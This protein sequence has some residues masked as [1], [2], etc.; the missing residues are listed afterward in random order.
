ML[1]LYFVAA[2]CTTPRSPDH[3][4]KNKRWVLIEMNGSPVQQSGTENEAHLIFNAD[5]KRYSGS[6]GCNRIG[7]DYTFSGKSNLKFSQS[8]STKMMCPDIERE[9]KFLSILSGIDSYELKGDELILKTGEKIL[10][11]FR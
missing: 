10:L 1:V 11:K 8:I 7:G 5:E 2:S 3:S 6:G 9:D 4:W